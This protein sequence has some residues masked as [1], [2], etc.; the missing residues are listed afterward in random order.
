MRQV[1]SHK[2]SAMSVA[3]VQVVKAARK[4]QGAC[5]RCRTPLPKGSIYRWYTVGFRSRYVHKRC[6]KPE[7]TPRMSELE[8][9]K[10]ADVYSAQESFEDGLSALENGDPGENSTVQEL[11][12]DFSSAVSDTA[13][14]YREA[15]DAIG[16]GGYT[17]SGEKADALESAADELGNFDPSV[18]MENV[19]PCD[20]HGDDFEPEE[21]EDADEIREACEACQEKRRGEWQDLI[22]EARSHAADVSFDG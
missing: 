20:E 15:D 18:D 10:M 21:G 6:M 7:C 16:G 11:L 12:D 5:E 2:E 14:E 9:S 19:E 8:S 4:D 3:R 1:E 22:E 13:G 17:E